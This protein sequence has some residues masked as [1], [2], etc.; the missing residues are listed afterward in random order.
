[1]IFIEVFCTLDCIFLTQIFVF[2]ALD[3]NFQVRALRDYDARTSSCEI[4]M[5]AGEILNV[6]NTAD[7]DWWRVINSKGKR[8]CIL[9]NMVQLIALD[10]VEVPES[11]DGKVI[12]FFKLISTKVFRKMYFPVRFHCILLFIILELVL[13]WRC[14]QGQGEF[15]KYKRHFGYLSMKECKEKCVSIIACEGIDYTI[16]FADDLGS[17][18]RLYGNNTVRSDGGKDNRTYCSLNRQTKNENNSKM[19]VF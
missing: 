17:S 10:D 8:G 14:K 5:K 9:S 2:I 7:G 13:S 11:G 18:C 19:K 12:S 1:M 15:E 4:S 3:V 6:T 16:K